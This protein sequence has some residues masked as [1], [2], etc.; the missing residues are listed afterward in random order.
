M[1]RG[2]VIRDLHAEESGCEGR[3][4]CSYVWRLEETAVFNYT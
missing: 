3:V 1:G 4:V 2:M